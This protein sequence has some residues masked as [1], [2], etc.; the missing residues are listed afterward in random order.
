MTN[1]TNLREIKAVVCDMDGLLFDT[2][3]I[4]RKVWQQACAECGHELPDDLYATFVG[5]PTADCEAKLL[6]FFGAHFPQ[7]EVRVLRRALWEAHVSECGIQTKSGVQELLDEIAQRALLSAV[8]TSTTRNGAL[9]CL[10]DLARRFNAIVT[11]DEVQRGKPAPDIFLLAASRLNVSPREC[12]VLEDSE[13]GAQ[14]AIAAGMKAVI[15]PDVI[16]PSPSVAAQAFRV[17]SS[18][19][20]VR[21]LFIEE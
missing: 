11:G 6:E 13:L 12:L 8:A 14:G 20:E 15:V 3:T 19:H 4:Y 16:Q 10:G 7:D 2:E 17:C 1:L 5:R 18:L 9:K 21:A